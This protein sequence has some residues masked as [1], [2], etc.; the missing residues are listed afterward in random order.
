MAFQLGKLKRV[1]KN[2]WKNLDPNEL[3]CNGPKALSLSLKRD[4]VYFFCV[5]IIGKLF[6]AEEMHLEA[7]GNICK[8]F[9]FQRFSKHFNLNR[10]FIARNNHA[11]QL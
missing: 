9:T 6:Y 8:Q 3:V 1:S 2:F 11:R 5:S 7:P 4:C 10:A